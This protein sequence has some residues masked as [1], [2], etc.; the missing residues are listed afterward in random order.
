MEAQKTDRE[1][2]I[3]RAGLVDIGTNF[4]LAIFK[5][6]VGVISNSIAIVSDALH[7][8]VDAI[9]GIIIIASSF[10]AKQKS[11][12]R[13]PEKRERVELMATTLIAAIIIIVGITTLVESVHK[14]I[15]PE[16]VEY[17]VPTIVILAVS[18]LG[19]LGLGI[20]LKRRGKAIQSDTLRASGVEATND[21]L[22]SG[23]VLASALIYV[24]WQVDIEAYVSVVISAI[25][26]KLGVELIVSQVRKTHK[27]N[28]THKF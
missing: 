20:Y 28:H 12:Q 6:V 19:K 11:V 8:M 22:I 2:V 16:E 9:S 27:K 26:I 13:S 17:S 5:I 25:I 10:V 4:A 18:V 7:G 3:F 23:A 24:I 14:I 1:K 15:E 21:V